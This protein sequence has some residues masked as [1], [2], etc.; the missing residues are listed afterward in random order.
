MATGRSPL[1]RDDGE[2]LPSV[3]SRSPVER[4]RLGVYA[5]L[6]ASAGAV[7]LPW[8]PD[9]LVRRVRG[10]VVHDVAVRHGVSL[11]VEAR[12]VLSE[13]AGPDGPRGLVAQTVRFVGLRLAARAL[14]SVGPVRMLWPVRNALQT[15]VLGHL[16]DRY[17]ALGRTERAVRVDASEARRVRQAIDGALAHAL[18]VESPEVREPTVIDDQ[19]DAL[20]AFVDGMLGLAAG[21]PGRLVGRLD[22]AFDELLAH[23]D[24]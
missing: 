11:G 23:G 5:A 20:T 15:Y 9:S 10:A 17:L 12:D 2:S 16:F 21:V 3:A 24:G 1:T 13:P 18:T 19:R 14:T 8:L 4:G 6:G 7:P 22:A